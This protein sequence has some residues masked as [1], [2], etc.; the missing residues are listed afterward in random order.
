MILTQHQVTVNGNTYTGQQAQKLR[1]QAGVFSISEIRQTLV[2]SSPRH[3]LWVEWHRGGGLEI[4]VS[5]YV[6][7]GSWTTGWPEEDR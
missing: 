3:Q 2:L 4:G 1:R 5:C 7:D 6:H